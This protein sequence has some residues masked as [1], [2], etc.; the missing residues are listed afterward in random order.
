MLFSCSSGLLG[1]LVGLL[2]SRPRAWLWAA[3]M[4]CASL[5]FSPPGL[6]HCPYSEPR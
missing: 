4:L 5:S 1:V 2:V 6:T 3:A